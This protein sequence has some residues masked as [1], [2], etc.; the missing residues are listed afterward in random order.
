MIPVNILL[1]SRYPE[2]V[3]RLAD[4]YTMRSCIWGELCILRPERKRFCFCIAQQERACR[5]L[6]IGMVC[7]QKTASFLV[8]EYCL[9]E[10][11]REPRIKQDSRLCRRCTPAERD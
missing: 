2:S 7:R 8:T 3:K 5:L 10:V 4:G 1:I 11:R 6:V 9:L